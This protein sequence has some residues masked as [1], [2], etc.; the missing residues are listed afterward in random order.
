MLEHARR[1]HL[2]GALVAE[3]EDRQA[4][5]APALGRQ[6]L[7]Q[8]LPLLLAGFGAIDRHEPARASLLNTSAR[9]LASA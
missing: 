7:L 8:Q 5:V 2:C 4:V 3:K 6:Y 9:R 1:N